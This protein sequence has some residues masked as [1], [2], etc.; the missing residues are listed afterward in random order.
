VINVEVEDDFSR[1][2]QGLLTY[3]MPVVVVIRAL[4]IQNQSKH[5]R[6]TTD[7]Y[8]E[9]ILTRYSTVTMKQCPNYTNILLE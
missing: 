2:E 8:E 6:Q 7:Q 5:L 4:S 9:Q 3:C 1:D